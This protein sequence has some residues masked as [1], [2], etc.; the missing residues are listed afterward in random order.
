MQNTLAANAGSAHSPDVVPEVLT[1]A[2]PRQA[3]A[4]YDLFCDIERVPE[5]MSIVRSAAVTTRDRHGR[6][7]DVAFLARLRGATIGYSLSYRYR[8]M[9][10]WLGWSTPGTS[11]MTILGCAQFTPLGEKSCLMTYSLFLDLASGGVPSWG[12]PQFDNHAAST[13][14]I[15]YRDFVMRTL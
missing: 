5:W 9:D 4:C 15:D 7:R 2:L 8:S 6:P 11:S 13:A 14:M 10:R 3:G 1:V 12:D